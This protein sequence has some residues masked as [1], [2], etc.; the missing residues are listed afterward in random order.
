MQAPHSVSLPPSPPPRSPSHS[1]QGDPAKH[2]RM[3]PCP[4]AP[5]RAGPPH[6][7]VFLLPVAEAS[8]AALRGCWMDTLRP[9]HT[10]PSAC[11]GPAPPHRANSHRAESLSVPG[12]ECC[13]PP[14]H[15]SHP[16]APR[17]SLR[18][19]STEPSGDELWSSRGPGLAQGSPTAPGSSNARVAK[20]KG[21]AHHSPPLS[22]HGVDI[23]CGHCGPAGSQWDM[24]WHLPGPVTNDVL[25]PQSSGEEVAMEAAG[26]PGRKERIRFLKQR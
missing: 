26:L 14:L 23:R 12:T 20:C 17:P 13:P 3:L 7:W 6:R 24:W 10:C 18:L 2:S 16:W 22:T 15:R 9:G 1:G 5:P 11:A 21:F 25:G 8:R 4:V 19:P